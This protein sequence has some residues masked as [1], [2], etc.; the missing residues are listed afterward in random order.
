MTLA[1]LRRG[2]GSQYLFHYT[3]AVGADLAIDDGIFVAGVEVRHGV[4]IYATDI[5][6]VDEATLDEVISECFEGSRSPARVD[7]V[8]AVRRAAGP[9]RFEQTSDPYQWLLSTPKLAP[10]VIPE[11][12]VAAA[13]WTG[14]VWRLSDD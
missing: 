12:Y 1:E 6:P 10:F 2:A 9:Y 14:R 7:H 11:I 5:A 13:I 3:D 8:I 4:G